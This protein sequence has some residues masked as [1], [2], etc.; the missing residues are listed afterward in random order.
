MNKEILILCLLFSFNQVFSQTNDK[1]TRIFEKDTI[2]TSNSVFDY[3]RQEEDS[4]VFIVGSVY[5]MPSDSLS[6]NEGNEY[7]TKVINPDNGYL[8]IYFKN[9]LLYK[10]RL[11]N[12][13]I[14][15]I[16]FCYYPFNSNIALQ[17]SFKEGKLHG[18]VFVQKVNGE[19]LEVMRFKKGKY[20]KHIYHWLS[21]SNK[22]LRKRSKHRSYNPL[23][24][25]EIIHR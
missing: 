13:K 14:E 25:D 11:I 22:A 3:F 5:L 19:I 23:R 6:F 15:R 4:I 16:G 1:K 21:F 18:L 9:K 10:Y 7:T 17:G 20:I 12:N 8:E 24:N 2:F